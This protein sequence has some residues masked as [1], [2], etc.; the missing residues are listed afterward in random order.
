MEQSAEVFEIV[1]ILNWPREVAT[2]GQSHELHP[3][4]EGR[5]HIWHE[6][7]GAIS[8]IMGSGQLNLIV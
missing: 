8:L 2:H 6:V 7:K 1:K 4:K 3:I 5:Q